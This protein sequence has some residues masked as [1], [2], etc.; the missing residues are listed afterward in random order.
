M[1]ISSAFVQNRPTISFEFF[2]PKT[3]E[4]VDALY[5]TMREELAPLTPT[6]ISVTYG[7]GGSTQDLT[8]ELV[9]NIKRATGVEAMCHLTCVGQSADKIAE[10]LDQLQ[11]NGIETI[12]ALRGDPP[13]GETESVK[14]EGGFA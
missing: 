3:P 4:G 14:P 5:R 7:A 11:E 8:V 12:L 2:P 13:R 6:Y 9:T 1:R 10:V